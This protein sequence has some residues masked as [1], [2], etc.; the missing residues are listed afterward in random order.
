M[1]LKWHNKWVYPPLSLWDCFTQRH[2]NV[3]SFLRWQANSGACHPHMLITP[4]NA[5]KFPF[6]TIKVKLPIFLWKGVCL[7]KHSWK[8]TVK[9]QVVVR[10][11]W[12]IT[13]SKIP[14]WWG[15][16]RRLN[17]KCI[18][19]RNDAHPGGRAIQRKLCCQKE[20]RLFATHSP[21]QILV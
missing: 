4:S 16:E 3:Y 11:L 2:K 5:I 7:I 13:C 10:V 15:K 8:M 12:K 19:Y 17:I 14:Q 9:R 6:S 21:Q 1:I 18:T 20:S